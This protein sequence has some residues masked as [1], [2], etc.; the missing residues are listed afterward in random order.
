MAINQCHSISIQVL[1]PGITKKWTNIEQVPD[2]SELTISTKQTV[3]FM[4]YKWRKRPFLYFP[5]I[6]LL[7]EYLSYTLTKLRNLLRNV[8]SK[9]ISEFSKLLLGDRL[10][11]FL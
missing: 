11:G 6:Y 1:A 7:I 8:H 2:K 4:M 5:C 3:F 9:I 10:L